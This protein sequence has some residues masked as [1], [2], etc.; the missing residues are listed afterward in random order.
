LVDKPKLE[1]CNRKYYAYGESKSIEIL[2]QFVSDIKYGT[3]TT[4]TAFF[5]AN[6]GQQNLLSYRTS[7]QLGIVEIINKVEESKLQR[8]SI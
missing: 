2:G 4:R 3:R 1:V 7:V 6:K 8:E 5:V